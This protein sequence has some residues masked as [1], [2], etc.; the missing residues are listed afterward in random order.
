M[1]EH[2]QP[3]QPPQQPGP[4]R[5]AAAEL[6]P[7]AKLGP[8]RLVQL[9]GE[10]GMGVVW[11]AEQHEPLA[12]RVAL[13]VIK[14][15]MDS[16]EVLARF[17]IE[18]EVLARL[19]H[20]NVA[21]VLDAGTTP[22][23]RPFFAMEYVP[24][25][26][27]TAW[28]DQQGLEPRDRIELFLAVC[29]GIQHAHRHAIIHRDIKPG[30]ILVAE[31]E[32]QAIPKV[33]DF[34][35]S[36]AMDRAQGGH[37]LYTGI[38]QLMGTLEYMSPEQAAMSS[39]D[40]D[41]RTDVYALGVILYELLTGQ[42]PFASKELREAGL[43]EV[44]RRIREEEPPLP[45]SR[46]STLGPETDKF[47]RSRGTTPERLASRLRGDLDWITMR[48]LEKERSRRYGSPAELAADLRR[49]LADEPVVARP[50]SQ[51]YRARK[52]VRRHTLPVVFAATTL[53][54]LLAF[55]AVMAL[56]A[57][58]LARERDRAN[59]EA[60][61]SREVTEFLVE[62]FG[63]VD[64]GE[65]RGRD[66][67][68][69]EV[70]DAGVVQLREELTGQERVKANL[71]RTMGRVYVELSLFEEAEPL[72]R[73]AVAL[74]E[75]NPQVGPLELAE[76]LV[77]LSRLCSWT[78]R[79]PEAEALARRSL[80]MREDELGPGSPLVAESLNAL[81]LALHQQDELDEAALVQARALRIRE[82]HF[83]PM[84]E[85]VAVSAHNLA[86]IHY[87]RDDMEAAAQLYR[88]SADIELERGGHDNHDY[89]TSLHTLSM[90][91]WEQ[92]QLDRALELQREALDI[93]E[94][95]LGEDHYHT[96]LSYAV[97][98]GMLTDQ[99][100][101]ARAIAS[102]ERALAILEERL[103]P[104]HPEVAW[105]QRLLD[106]ARDSAAP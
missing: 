30:N 31:E 14:P 9:L 65:N 20:P 10:G 99:G 75:A 66:I 95:V 80:A 56:Q 61:T 28:A 19:N 105:A 88:R 79:L 5:A 39:L 87:F 106:A 100:Q 77:A 83:G 96:G 93:R 1:T 60:A 16:R 89:A 3:T 51:G 84:S 52:F 62:L 63:E 33:I 59:Q 25:I 91:R 71:L 17:D 94:R 81:G 85:E 73:E 74:A 82:E 57:G 103:G 46:L 101:A 48:A 7:G 97:M 92:E 8:Y 44:R 104:E 69:R 54:L 2:D 38:G 26:P 11:L 102:G 53:L 15:G 70:L 76:N 98:C 36:K 86:T 90:V 68:A 35:V 43:D 58:R 22:A 4:Q 27:I 37:T 21:R 47:A 78:D 12:R 23:G 13:K 29:E 18:R 6:Q 41:T 64:P 45:S 49:Y 50:P 55:G 40:I 32:G 34:G 42:L 72:L 24:G 67:S